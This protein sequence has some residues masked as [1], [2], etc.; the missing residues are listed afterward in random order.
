MAD[1]AALFGNT[2][3]EALGSAMDAAGGAA[4]S[5]SEMQG[6]AKGAQSV[7]DKLKAALSNLAVAAEPLLSV[8]HFVVD[9]LGVLLSIPGAPYIMGFV[10]AFVLLVGVGTKVKGAIDTAKNG[11]K[12]VGEV[13]KQSGG[14]MAESI[15]S[16]GQAAASSAKGL[17]A[18]GA[19]ALMIGGAI[20]IAALGVAELVSSF[21]GFS[22]GEIL[23]IAVALLVFGAIM[24]IMVLILAKMSPVLAVAGVGLIIFGVAVAIVAAAV[25]IMAK[26][27]GV[28]VKEG[29][30]P[31]MPHVGSLIELAA[32]LMLMALA[33]ILLLPA[34]L[35]AAIGL[36]AMG[37]GFAAL[38]LGLLL[39]SNDDLREIGVIFTALGKIAENGATGITSLVP[40]IESIVDSLT[41]SDAILRLMIMTSAIRSLVD[42]INDLDGTSAS[43]FTVV[44]R[45]VF[46]ASQSAKDLTPDM[47][48]NVG[49]LVEVADEYSSLK[50]SLFG[51]DGEAQKDFADML[52]SALGGAGG[53]AGRGTGGGTAPS[54]RSSTIV[55]ELDGKELGR[56]VESL[57]SRRNKLRTTT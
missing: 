30:L 42:A 52:K 16:V 11:F 56:T 1:A 36:A 44:M 53:G 25:Y 23:A 54:S 26:A 43:Q 9:I 7:S 45:E 3:T 12:S 51:G 31:L 27:F 14:G 28:F 2:S 22:A 15:K 50:Y 38:G 41:D 17:L 32:G 5:L 21:K 47:V 4:G 55:L 20:A 19:A 24:V 29:V 34:G 57:L 13:A 33:G 37:L 6:A 49:K 35:A 10:A 48:D 39:V 40:A 46:E 8:L 18:L